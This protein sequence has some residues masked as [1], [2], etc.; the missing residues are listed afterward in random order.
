VGQLA[1][2]GPPAEALHLQ[3]GR[4][5]DQAAPAVLVEPR[6]LVAPEVLVGV[7]DLEVSTSTDNPNFVTSATSFTCT[8]VWYQDKTKYKSDLLVNLNY[9]TDKLDPVQKTPKL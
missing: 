4:E 3:A 5:V 7:Q 6:G 2:A 9:T 1:A 8:T